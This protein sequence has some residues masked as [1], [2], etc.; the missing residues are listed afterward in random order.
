M[1]PDPRG[2]RRLQRPIE[3]GQVQPKG[4]DVLVSVWDKVERHDPRRWAVLRVRD[5]G[6]GIPAQDL[7]RVFEQLY[8][9]LGGW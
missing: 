6:I 4:G 8:R 1:G 7:P 5:S 2:A 9:V 3:R